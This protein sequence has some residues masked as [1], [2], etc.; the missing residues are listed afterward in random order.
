[1]LQFLH[2]LSVPK[3]RHSNMIAHANQLGIYR[4]LGMV[5]E[6]LVFAYGSNVYFTTV[7]YLTLWSVLVIIRVQ[8]SQR[9]WFLYNARNGPVH[10]IVT[11]EGTKVTPI[12]IRG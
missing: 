12:Y 10:T 9:C 3:Q 1:M 11:H 5:K 2:T 7:S 4:A 8:S 6:V